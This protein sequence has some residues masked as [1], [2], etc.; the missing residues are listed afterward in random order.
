MEARDTRKMTYVE[1]E[2]LV[3]SSDV[4]YE[5]VNGEVFAMA[6]GT[7]R[8]SAICANV[9]IALGNALRGKPCRVYQS[10]L[11]VRVEATGLS[12]YPDVT[13]VCG[14]LEPSP[15]DRVAATNPRVLVEVTSESTEAY[16]RGPKFQHYQ[17]IP[18]LTDYV[19]VSA[20]RIRID[21]YRRQSDGTW[22]LT[23]VGPVTPT[24]TR[25]DSID[26]TLTLDDAY[27]QLDAVPS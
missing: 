17:S 27:A 1:Y 23:P 14:P 8:H 13:I 2:A 19:I 20:D 10:D 6:G 3:A 21:H 26:V 5:Y 7:P 22:V 11:R 16:D 18:S 12:T 15:K 24:S 9:L 25:L 4:K